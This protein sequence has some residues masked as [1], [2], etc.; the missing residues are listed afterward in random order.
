[1]PVGMAFLGERGGEGEEKWRRG[2]RGEV[3]RYGRGEE[4]NGRR[5]MGEGRR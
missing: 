4:G 1:M 2:M 5:G 3:E